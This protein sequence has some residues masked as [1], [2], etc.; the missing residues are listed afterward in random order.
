MA[1]IFIYTFDD[2][3]ITKDN[4][5]ND[6]KDIEA[7]LKKKITPF[8][9][10]KILG[11]GFTSIK[12]HKYGTIDYIECFSTFQ[13]SLGYYYEAFIED[14]DMRT[15]KIHH[16]YFSKAKVMITSN[17]KVIV[18]FDW[19][20]EENGRTKVKS[21]LESFGYKINPIRIN[22]D[23]LR[24]VQKKY[25]WLGAKIEKI[26]KGG[27][28]TKRVSY[29]IDPSDEE[30]KSFVDEQ[31]REYG[32]LC[33]LNFELPFSGD[34]ENTPSRINVKLYSDGGHRI[35]INESEFGDINDFR[36]FQ[37]HLTE[38]LVKFRNESL[39]VNS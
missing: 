25:T 10:G 20:A 5:I 31:Y 17:G 15:E 6:L 13:C 32:K 38:V 19:A 23:L 34:N 8:E 16:Q 9:Q 37:I 24:R 30:A 27:D 36:N 1:T 29:E 18:K 33:H 22:D 3:I 7:A 14:G 12:K 35:V 11:E 28:N 39:G 26:N 4:G 21:L 2:L